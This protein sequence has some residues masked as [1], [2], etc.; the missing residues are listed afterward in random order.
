[1]FQDGSECFKMRQDVSGWFRMIQKAL[2]CSGMLD[3]NSGRSMISKIPD[4]PFA[5]DISGPVISP[6]P[7]FPRMFQEDLCERDAGGGRPRAGWGWRLSFEVLSEG[8][9]FLRESDCSCFWASMLACRA[10]GRCIWRIETSTSFSLSSF[11]S[12]SLSFLSFNPF[13]S[14]PKRQS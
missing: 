8:G 9:P 5:Q 7:L 14:A 2:G 11:F 13:F 3:S 10:G 12:I 4:D 6:R 1:M